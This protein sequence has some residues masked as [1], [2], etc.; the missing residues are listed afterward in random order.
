MTRRPAVFLDRDGV[1]NSLVYHKD[2]SVVDSP[3][4][5]S[6]FRVLPRVPQAIR[7]LNE[8]GLVVVVASNQP[9]I[10]KRHFTSATL[11]EFDQK[12][13]KCLQP[14]G[15][16]IDG[17]Y[18]CLHHPDSRLKSLRRRCSCRKPGIGMLKE[19]AH[20]LG[21]SLAHSYMVGDGLTDIEAGS[22]AGCRTI[23]IGRWKCELCQF[24]HPY[25]LRPTY[26]APNLWEATR[27]IQSDI[28]SNRA[29][30]NESPLGCPAKIAGF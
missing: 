6:Q 17:I 2:A 13:R 26:I 12:L 28:R 30:G 16:R 24:I 10:A 9:G 3:F 21:L 20:D 4:T 25:N 18:Y 8:L 11:R 7:L 15:A 23:F 1:I 14:T 19:A 29:S 22:R 5:L 27:W